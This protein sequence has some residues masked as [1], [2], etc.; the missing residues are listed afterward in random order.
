[1]NVRTLCEPVGLYQD[2]VSGV[3][4]LG[5]ALTPTMF[6]LTRIAGV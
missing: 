2:H 6:L 5:G 1:M 4:P 3:Y